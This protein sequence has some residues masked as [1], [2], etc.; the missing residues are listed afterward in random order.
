[1]HIE[2]KNFALRPFF[3][4][5]VYFLPSDAALLRA[6]HLVM[7]S[8]DSVLLEVEQA[9]WELKVDTAPGLDGVGAAFLKHAVRR[10]AQRQPNRAAEYL[11]AP[12]LAEL[13]LFVFQTRQIPY[14]WKVAR[15]VPFH[16]K[17]D[18]DDPANYRLNAISSVVHHWFASVL[19]S[20]L[21]KWCIGQGVLPIK[22]FCFVPGRNCQQAHFLFRHLSQSRK[23]WGG[24]HGKQ[25]WLSFNDFKAAYD[26]VDRR[27]LWNH[28]CCLI[29]VSDFFLVSNTEYV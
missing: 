12:V 3:A 27:A 25:M 18:R 4:H 11:L 2:A 8:V 16:K 10:S 23:V 15:L 17:G 20:L 26:H 19:N 24:R 29:G 6:Q 22:Q 13:F 14:A 28:L 1:M 5:N 7:P 21:T 9:L